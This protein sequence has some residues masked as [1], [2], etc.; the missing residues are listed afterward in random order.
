MLLKELDKCRFVFELLG[1]DLGR[2]AMHDKAT[3]VAALAATTMNEA[4]FLAALTSQKLTPEQVKGRL[5][6][7]LARL[8]PQASTYR[9]DMQSRIH[10]T[11]LSEATRWLREH[12]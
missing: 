4:V 9:C 1:L 8:S 5:S 2:S 6:T 10:A 11:L 7:A 12:D 3:A